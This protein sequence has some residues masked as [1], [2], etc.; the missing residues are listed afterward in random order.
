M[1]TPNTDLVRPSRDGDQFHYLRAARLCL[2]LLSPNSVLTAVTIEGVSQG[3]D[4]RAGLDVIDM[5]LYYGSCDIAQA[6]RVHY[7][8]FKH[9]TLHA[10]DQ[11]TA[12]G[13]KR[14]FQGFAARYTHLVR[15]FG[16]EDIAERFFFEFESNRPIA[17]GV[18][19][20]LA[21][22]VVGKT[23]ARSAYLRCA[24][25]LSEAELQDFSKLV[26][27][28]PD[29]SDY[30]AQR[31]LFERDFGAYLPD[32][33][34]DA[35]LKLKELVTR[36]ATSEYSK[37]PII[38]REDVLQA[39]GADM[40]DLFPASP[41]IELPHQIV[42]R[43][44]MSTL[45]DTIIAAPG[46]MILEADGGVGKSVVASRIGSW[47]SP[48]SA[49][50]VYDCFG[51][52]AYRS[53]SGYRHRPRDGL[54]QLANEM[55]THFLCDP[56]IPTPKGDAAAFVRAFKARLAQASTVIAARDRN[57]LLLIVIDAADN[58][59][60]A[61]D[62]A[63]DGLSFP[64]LL[65]RE[66]F[67]QNV[68]I[69]LTARSHRVH[70]LDSPPEIPR[71]ELLPFSEEETK[72]H[73]RGRFPNASFQDV[74]EFHRL[75][76]RNP[77]VQKAALDAENSVSD[78]LA[79]L[80]PMPKS[81]SDTI[82]TLLE[83]AIAKV[84]DAAA[85]IE[86]PQI[87]RL[88]ATLATLRP[89]V[90][91]EV[92]AAMAE[93]PVEL[94]RSISHDLGRPLLI[95]EDAVQFR[96]EPTETWFRERFRPRPAALGAFV[97]R[98]KPLALT[99][100]YVAAVLPQ[101]MLEA[102]EFDEL[103]AL[104]LSGDALPTEGAISRRDVEFQRLQFALKAALRSK[105]FSDAAKLAL[106]AGGEAAA[107]ARQQTLLSGN[108]DL[109]ARFLDDD[110][111]VDQVSR[112]L[113]V[114][115]SWTGSEHA[116]GACLLSGNQ[117]LDGDARSCL[118]VAYDW[119]NHWIGRLQ[120]DETQRER[121]SDADIAELQLA[122]L[123][124]HGPDV[125]AR[126]LRR[127]RPREVSFRVGRILVGRLV[128]ASRFDEIDALAIAAGND[129][130]LLFAILIE[131]CA[132]A[133][134]PPR[135]V[136]KRAF[137]LTASHRVTI[138]APGGWRGEEVRL[139]AINALVLAALRH[140]L[141]SKRA[142]ARILKRYLS[143]HPPRSLYSQFSHNERSIHLRAYA[144]RAV[145]QGRPLSL[146][147]LVHPDLRK[148]FEATHDHNADVRRLREDVGALL[149]WHMLSAELN[150]GRVSGSKL[151]AKIEEARQASKA[152]EGHSYHERSETADEIALIWSDLIIGSD[153]SDVLWRSFIDW[154]SKLKRPLFIPTLI[155]LARRVA[156]TGGQ[157]NVTFA[158][159][160]QA[161]RIT[162]NEKE[163]AES[164]ADIY[165][166]LARAVLPASDA[167]ARQYFE[168][169]IL[170]SSR[171][172]EENLSR[173]HALLHLADASAGEGRD[174]PEN[175]YRFARAAELTYA[176]VVRDKHFD[177]EHTVEALA[178][179]SAR[180]APTILSRWIDRRFGN[181]A[182]LLP[183]LIGELVRKGSLDGPTVLPLIGLRAEW[184]YGSLLEAALETVADAD[185]RQALAEDAFRYLRFAPVSLKDGRYLRALLERYQIE[186]I[187]LEPMLR[188]A[189]ECGTARAMRERRPSP[190]SETVTLDWEA[191]FAS[192]DLTTAQDIS[193]ALERYRAVG[194]GY[195]RQEFFKQALP[196][197]A[198]GQ[199]RAFLEAYGAGAAPD[200]YELRELLESLPPD[201]ASRISVR[202][203]LAR[204]ARETYRRCAGSVFVDRHYQ[205]LPL[206]LVA[207]ATGLSA[208][209]LINEAVDAIGSTSLPVS[210]GG[211]FRLVGLLAR[212][213]PMD[214]ALEALYYGLDLL[215]PALEPD[216]GD[217]PWI[218][219]LAPPESMEAAVAGYLWAALGSTEASRRW[220]A[221]HAVRAFC[222]LGCNEILNALVDFAGRGD[223][224][225]F[226]DRQLHFY[227]FHALQ[228]LLIALA[229]AAQESGN[230]VAGH[231]DFL[232][233][234]GSRTNLHIA[235][236]GF[237]A[238]ALLSLHAQGLVTLT[239]E[240]QRDLQT[241][242]DSLL[243]PV[244]S[245][246]FE[247][248][249]G[250]RAEGR[251]DRRFLF[252]YD[253]DK[254]WIA[255]LA[256]CFSLS[257][258]EVEIEA[259]KVICDDWASDENG[260]WDH[261]TRAVRGYF[262]DDDRRSNGSAA[263]NDD[264]SFYLSYHALMIT[265]GK[266]LNTKPLRQNPEDNWDSFERWLN[267]QGLTRS[268]GHWLADRRDRSPH[269]CQH[270]PEMEDADW[271]A[272]LKE[273]DLPSLLRP[274]SDVV[275]VAGRWTQYAGRRR[276]RISIR[277]A[278]VSS[279]RLRA[280]ARALV[281]AIN[282]HLYGVPSFGDRLEIAH[283]SYALKGWV[284]EEDQEPRID[285]L[286]PWAT[287][288]STKPFVPA[289]SF[290]EL[291]DL[292]SDSL[293]RLW[294]DPADQP[295]LRSEVWSEGED[296]DDV[297]S[298]GGKRLV[299]S[300][301]FLDRMM[302]RAGKSMLFKVSIERQLANDKFDRMAGKEDDNGSELTGIF[303]LEQ[304]G[305][306]S[307]VRRNPRPG[308]KARR[309][310]ETR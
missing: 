85:S 32:N 124:L 112:R 100:A 175:A 254:H 103:V 268:D 190:I 239:A 189:E 120:S 7:R 229:R 39:I 225:P 14:T 238:D 102:G 109:A 26:R 89:F 172:G 219:E 250:S 257:N 215:E 30:L 287:G 47:L 94:V 73:L 168:E 237:A 86:Q 242:N 180:S 63:Q 34:K 88:C 121:M 265:A 217:G 216:D 92:V 106:K 196:R 146:K 248:A 283:G 178:G 151:P 212:L 22:L 266:L 185:Q 110:Q 61:A 1:N 42:E 118:R 138:R 23:S 205:P 197:V 69:V 292:R 173:W 200:L 81:V 240:E 177:W 133:R 41:H 275:V 213:I 71:I 235:M 46:V 145:L 307:P 167:E 194:Q 18:A 308:R 142:L 206:D 140:R 202:P 45:S 19:N 53:P 135:K 82:G 232:R 304:Q 139:D 5:A 310:V 286:D 263:R 246:A 33:D 165:V 58:A 116:Y 21:D 25:G 129:L 79:A 188:R 181:E 262:R 13:L 251:S 269:D 245:K 214:A 99:S 276:Q 117:A 134:V 51:N 186:K 8:Q 256:R 126:Q 289:R 300:H 28:L 170:V 282:P 52:G 259:E 291:M 264:L 59:Q 184:A 267:D 44:Q 66:S 164:K 17:P 150:S 171:I 11:W 10:H 16:P 125:C 288:V 277:S 295:V 153:K 55:A 228:W 128:D 154:N 2:E 9:S 122:E 231:A 36:K 233:R 252:G 230:I 253:F 107:D 299:A 114:G 303:T 137:V 20:A 78:V 198:A 84:R 222:R 144:L 234:H 208:T 249:D 43:E 161:F 166:S 54:V 38:R 24:I 305:E 297:R 123:N 278:L 301:S 56:L 176:Y 285:Q 293:Q 279:D 90:P 281:S 160:E 156:R 131:L 98:L 12:S 201:W 76:S 91:I 226:V 220:E 29:T 4:I 192:L 48:G 6:T 309:R 50:F 74:R 174:E 270:L 182:R 96:D 37:N 149:P 290:D 236:R 159:A 105:R 223:G 152:A 62:E 77:R 183:H 57:A 158:F 87:D 141:G 243:P 271:S 115:G 64:R 284:S 68:R 65:V 104:A 274:R 15:R 218:P 136:V 247:R 111:L 258:D 31:Q 195:Y 179:L 296:D 209:D 113:I 108:T 157:K 227:E 67:P 187:D 130:G 101:L 162:D 70:L 199:E 35:P 72:E 272:S 127:W 241:I 211:L 298:G 224:G 148:A 280:L 27:L 143:K 203:A 119:L 255:P 49:T 80:G 132:V 273:E 60:M 97:A 221:A 163:H 169:A 75:T 95:R 244:H 261:D 191:V 260:H 3:E 93:V 306:L 210:A 147:R 40:R 155:T 204:L 302:E 294:R 207:K 83:S 193:I